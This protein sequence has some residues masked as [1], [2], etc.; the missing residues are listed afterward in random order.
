[1][2]TGPISYGDVFNALERNNLR[3]VVIGGVAVV[4][5][6]HIRP[7]IDLDIVVAPTPDEQKRVLAVLMLAGFVPTVPLPLNLLRVLRMFD[8]SERELDV[9]V[10][11][12]IPFDELWADSVQIRVGDSVVRVISLEHLLRAKQITG[13]PLDLMD[14]EGLLAIQKSIPKVM[15]NE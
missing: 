1:M 2:S 9:F 13:R 15:S 7:V 10:K 6:G 11:Y 5:H 14:V 8:Q 12:H 4:L 3:Y